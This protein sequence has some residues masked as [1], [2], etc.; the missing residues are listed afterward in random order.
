[1]IDFSVANV[2][3]HADRVKFSQTLAD[4]FRYW[5]TQVVLRRA[6]K[7]I[8]LLCGS[9]TLN[10]VPPRPAENSMMDLWDPPLMSLS[11]SCFDQYTGCANK[12]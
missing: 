12:K 4:F 11:V 3:D 8:L 5:F 10:F 7:T 9:L 6:T 1:V 2:G